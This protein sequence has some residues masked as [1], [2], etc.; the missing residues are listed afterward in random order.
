MLTQ[1]EK[2]LKYIKKE[3]NI[4]FS[5]LRILYGSSL[6]L[7]YFFKLGKANLISHN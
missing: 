3:D 4:L 1:H 7:L 2:V 5:Y 6:F